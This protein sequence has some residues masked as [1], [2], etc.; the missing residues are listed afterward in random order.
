MKRSNL[1]LILTLLLT[2]TALATPP[3]ELANLPHAD[4]ITQI[5]PPSTPEPQLRSFGTQQ[6]DKQPVFVHVT[7]S[8][9]ITQL[10]TQQFTNQERKEL[11]QTMREFAIHETR[12]QPKHRYNTFNGFTAELTP[13][14]QQQ[15]LKH[16]LVDKITPNHQVTLF[17]QDTVDIINATSTW[18]TQIEE[19]NLT[20][21]GQAVCVIDT[22]IRY[23]H[24]EFGSCTESEFL[25]GECKKVPAGINYITGEDENNPLDDN[26][27]GTHVAGTIAANHTYKGVAPDTQLLVVRALNS[28]GGLQ[29]DI[30]KG[31]EWC[32]DQAQT[33]NVSAISMSLGINGYLNDSYCDADYPWFAEPINNATSQGISVVA[34]SG[35]DGS[36]TGIGSPACIQNTI[37]VTS[38]DKSDDTISSFANRNAL[39]LLAAPG[40][41]I[42]SAWHTGNTTYNTIQGTS[43]AT[44][45]VS[46]A[47]AIINQY[48]QSVEQE[49]T[50]QEIELLLNN[51]GKPITDGSITYQRINVLQTII[52]L[53]SAPQTTASF[54][55]DWQNTPFNVTLNATGE[56][57]IAFTSYRLNNQSWENDTQVTIN[58]S[59]NH[60]L[61]FFSENTAGIR[62]ETQVIYPL[63]D[64]LPPNTTSNAPT[65]WQNQPINVTLNATDNLSGIN[66]TT[67]RVNNQTWINET[68][69]LFNQSAN[70]TLEYYSVDQA[71]NQELTNTRQ[72][73]LDLT[74]P[75]LSVTAPSAWQN[76]SFVI[77]W[78]SFDN[79]SGV[80]R[81]E[82]RVDTGSWTL[83][84]NF[85][86]NESGNFTVDIRAVDN[87]NNT[88]TASL[89]ALLDVTP[90]NTT[91][92]APTNWQNQPINV[93]LNATDNLSG[94][95]HTTYRVN[96]QTWI[97][98]T[99]ILVNESG[100]HLLEYYS[101]DNVGNQEPT[102]NTTVRVDLQAPI[103]NF[104]APSTWQNTSFN[105][106]FNPYDVLSG[107][108]NSWMQQNN[109]TP[110]T[111]TTLT[112]EEQGVHNVTLS[113][114]DN[115][116]N[117]NQ[118][119]IQARL[120]T[121]PPTTTDNA[122]SG[123][124]NTNVT[125]FFNATD[126][127]SGINHTTY[128]VNETSWTNG[129]AV[130][131]SDGNYTIEYYSID[132]AGNQEETRN[133][134]LLID[135]TPPT[136]TTFS[137][138]ETQAQA[139]QTIRFDTQV[140]DTNQLTN[141]TLLVD[142]VEQE[143]NNTGADAFSQT[144]N[145]P[146]G[147]YTAL[148]TAWDVANNTAEETLSFTVYEQQTFSNQELTNT[149]AADIDARNQTRTKLRIKS[150]QTIT[151]NITILSSKQKPANINQELPRA[152]RHSTIQLSPN[153]QSNLS[154]ANLSVGYDEEDVQGLDT[155]TLRMEYYNQSADTW[156]RLTTNLS[157]VHAVGVDTSE[158]E[159]WANVTRFSTYAITADEEEEE[160]EEDGSGN[161]D[162][163]GGGTSSGGGGGGGGAALTQASNSTTRT[164]TFVA[165]NNAV[166][167]NFNNAN[168]AI[169]KI[170]FTPLQDATS[171]TLTLR[172]ETIPSDAPAQ[173]TQYLELDYPP[174]LATSNV[175]L[176]YEASSNEALFRY[177]Q[178][179]WQELPREE[180]S[181]GVYQATSSGLS[182][183]A[184]APKEATRTQ[185]PE[186]QEPAQEP[187]EQETNQTTTTQEP[188][189]TQAELIEG[190][191]RDNTGE[192]VLLYILVGLAL[193]VVTA[194]VYE[195]SWNKQD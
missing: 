31:I 111:N 179:T 36:T 129:T 9:K 41:G 89:Q 143:M 158:Q 104:T 135:T 30:V 67:Y 37:S 194:L 126:N 193:L 115:A 11:H 69:I 153:L 80:N 183:F 181:P 81:T 145:L 29:G 60:T 24:Q 149:S 163:N 119:T 32:I 82:Y 58:T 162:N 62:E 39:T 161:D 43:M 184:L 46:A 91:S 185:T 54:P 160:E 99:T 123:W 13:S 121:T 100:E 102:K 167:Y 42:T 141:V 51:T 190:Q 180:I 5:A 131:L 48:L 151:A 2:A 103:L 127:L 4:L 130:T 154:W 70:Y 90:P 21:H 16:P 168:L 170:S 96:N 8:Q 107:V 122:P 108:N 138:N 132:N 105:I 176:E 124:Q 94:I 114:T 52:E 83:A 166:T 191:P 26:G 74:P 22:G 98:G 146:V 109:Q 76:T 20:G 73:L 113:A 117:T 85:T 169:K 188:E 95:N 33:Y 139:N 78:S 7:D 155:N 150:K 44:P 12:Q 72:V 165:A 171:L 53:S 34:A 63:L 50:P 187:L 120:D 175:T 172:R 18:Q 152:L 173:T 186:E 61:E 189:Q 68:T 133:T 1:L 116:N 192:K 125:L 101:I 164:Q 118:T 35:N 49:K 128:R 178:T 57:D 93:T 144:R 142:G 71:S 6:E 87:V 47:V 64:L 28:D 79:F 106:T 147:T 140:T 10:R 55:N 136:I 137:I 86:V 40:R 88:N 110:T 14:E 97:N 25:A 75:S 19:Q 177:D 156:I 3:P 112:I 174:G 23:D 148:V 182:R 195:K 59:A 15:L 77:N 159:V 17:M 27:H 84:S 157:W 65:N 66:H 38:T 56:L 45:H 134:T 92:N